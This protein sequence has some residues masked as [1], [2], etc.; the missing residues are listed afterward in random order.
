MDIGDQEKL[1]V[2]QKYIMDYDINVV[3]LLFFIGEIPAE[4][5]DLRYKMVDLLIVFG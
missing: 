5:V 2:Y 1:W 3:Y 4:V